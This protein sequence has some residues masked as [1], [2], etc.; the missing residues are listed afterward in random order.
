MSAERAKTPRQR[1]H[2][3]ARIALKSRG[4]A[5]VIDDL[6]QLANAKF[7]IPKTYGQ[8]LEAVFINTAGGLTGGDT[9][10]VE[11]NAGRETSV[12]FSTQACERIYK[13]IDETPAEV[14]N[15]IYVAA[16][17]HAVWLPQETILFDAGRLNRKLSVSLAAGAG[18]TGLEA[19]MLG[20]QAMGETVRNGLLRDEWSIARDGVPIYADIARLDCDIEAKLNSFAHLGGHRIFA[21]LV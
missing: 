17:A 20:R 21:T 19:V 11:I 13:A 10:G 8:S 16:G 18:F 12:V 6:Y 3:R 4:G 15:E 5:T 9:L 1:S 14:T 7:R 2:G